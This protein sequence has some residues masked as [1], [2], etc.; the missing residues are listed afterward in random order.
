MVNQTKQLLK[1]IQGNFN[2]PKLTPIATDMY[3][4]NHSGTHDAGILNK[5]PTKDNDLVNKKY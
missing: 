3:V 5:T 2:P 4:P 1:N